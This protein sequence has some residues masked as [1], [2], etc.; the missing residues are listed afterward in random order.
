MRGT[1]LATLKELQVAE[2]NMISSAPNVLDVESQIEASFNHELQ[3]EGWKKIYSVLLAHQE[4]FAGSSKDLGHCEI[5]S[6][7]IDTGD[8]RPNH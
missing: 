6:H 4:C 2:L 1:T 7:N 3:P 5:L 8:N